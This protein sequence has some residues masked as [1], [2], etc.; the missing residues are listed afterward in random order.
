MKK[1]TQPHSIE[2]R[3]VRIDNGVK[4]DAGAVERLASML[5]RL[6]VAH[7]ELAQ[8]AHALCK[9]ESHAPR[10]EACIKIGET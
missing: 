3:D 5:E 2:I 8:A 7:L 9:G 6:A 4:I 10:F 1:R